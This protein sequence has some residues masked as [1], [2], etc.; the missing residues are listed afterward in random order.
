[1]NNLE[2][3]TLRGPDGQPLDLTSPSVKVS[4]ERVALEA[5]KG[6]RWVYDLKGPFPQEWC[7]VRIAD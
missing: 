2:E 1:M 6:Y 3:R 7:K 4:D 5:E